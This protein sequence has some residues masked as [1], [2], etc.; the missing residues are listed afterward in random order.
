SSMPE[1]PEV[2]HAMQQL[3]KA[4]LGRT[5]LVVRV[6]HPALARSLPTSAQ[7]KL[8]GRTVHEV[9]RRAKLQLVTLD[10]GSTLEVHFRM[11]GDWSF[12]AANDKPEPL[13]R[14]R[15]VFTDGSRVSLID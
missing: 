3:R 11:T 1:L 14:G 6:M 7:R 12:G 8:K 13:E 2:E 9:Q 5:I 15:I 4:A 10:D